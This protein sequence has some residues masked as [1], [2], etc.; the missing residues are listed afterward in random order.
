MKVFF[1]KIINLLFYEKGTNLGSRCSG[2]K[3]YPLGNNCYG[4]DDCK[5]IKE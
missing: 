1:I 5:P 4:C 3:V 2:Y